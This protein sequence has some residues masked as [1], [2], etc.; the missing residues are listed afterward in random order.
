MDSASSL[1]MIALLLMVLA[2]IARPFIG[3][4]DG[5]DAESGSSHAV[6]RKRADLLAER[7]RVYGAIRD[8]DV[9]Y[10]TNKVSAVDYAAQRHELVAH[11]VEVLQQL[12]ALPAADEAAL[13]DPVEA[14]IVAF[15]AG[16]TAEAAPASA[17]QAGH[18]MFCPRCGERVEAGDQFCVSCGARL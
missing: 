6:M 15:Q 18:T 9:D 3:S 14:A 7:N 5:N 16:G 8:L 10:K 13:E 4:D 1:V 12:D 11:G 17:R 2:F